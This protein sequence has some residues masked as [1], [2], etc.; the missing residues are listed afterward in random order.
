MYFDVKSNAFSCF[1]H[2]L[3][4]R[5]SLSDNYI[6][7]VDMDSSE[8][9]WIATENGLNAYNPK[10]KI[11]K[12]YLYSESDPN[13]LP[14]RVAFDVEVRKNGEVWVASNSLVCRLK[15]K[16]GIFENRY[17]NPIILER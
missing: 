14:G 4:D 16:Q 6:Y 10:A 17:N 11:W 5:N 12:R 3:N 7:A 2:N 13:S 1:K 9:I 15:S 8:T